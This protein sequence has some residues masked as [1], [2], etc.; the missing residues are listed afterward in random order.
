MFFANGA[1]DGLAERYIVNL[2]QIDEGL[3]FSNAA[4]LTID[5][6]SHFD[7]EAFDWEFIFNKVGIVF[8]AN[9]SDDWC[10]YELLVYIKSLLK[11]LF[12]VFCKSL[13]NLYFFVDELVHS[14]SI[15]K[16]I[17]AE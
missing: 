2:D 8:A 4:D 12:L 13:T 1:L 17:E 9:N 5:Y 14:A 3:I 16:Y 10:K 7:V 11:L 6:I 15:I